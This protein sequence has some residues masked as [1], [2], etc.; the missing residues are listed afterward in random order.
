MGNYAFL[1][2]AESH[3]Y[4]NM[5]HWNKQGNLEDNND[6]A[7]EDESNEMDFFLLYYVLT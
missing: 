7:V 5:S 2:T 3:I 4:G 1:H 6:D